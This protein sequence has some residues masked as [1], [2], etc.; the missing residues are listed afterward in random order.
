MRFATEQITAHTPVLLT[1]EL[2]TVCLAA[3]VSQQNAG[4]AREIVAIVEQTQGMRP[5]MVFILPVL[6]L[7]S[8]I[9]VAA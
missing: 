3:A 6:I 8:K 2:L 4:V 9:Q 1:R 5:T 7:Y